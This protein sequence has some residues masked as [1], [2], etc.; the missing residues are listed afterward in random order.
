MAEVRATT[1]ISWGGSWALGLSL[2]TVTTAFHAFGIVMILRGLKSSG[3]LAR[4]HESQIRHPLALAVV[5]IAL[6]GLLLAVLHGMEAFLWAA[7]YLLIGAIDS[8]RD[9]ILYSLDSFTTRGAK[10]L[11]LDPAWR[12][13][14]ALESA[15]GML[16]F[17]ISTAFVFTVIQRIGGIIDELD[18][19]QR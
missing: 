13:M 19:S 7:A 18:R 1:E 14:G 10:D 3:Q 15:D 12:L 9:A 2:I 6:V 11:A 5:V 4:A 8:E 17:G 16:L